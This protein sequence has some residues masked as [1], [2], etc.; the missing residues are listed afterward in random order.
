MTAQ[1]TQE[2]RMQESFSLAFKRTVLKPIVRGLMHVLPERGFE[3]FYATAFPAYKFA[4]RQSYFMSSLARFQFRDAGLWQRTRRVYSVA[5]YSLVGMGGLEATYDEAQRINAERVPSDFVEL[6]VARGGAAALLSL[7]AFDK[8]APEQRR[9]WLFDSYE[10]LPEPGA[11]DTA[12]D[13]TTGDHVRPLPKGSCLGTLDAVR[14]LLIDRF[15]LPADRINFVKGWFQD[16][17]PVTAPTMGKIAL[18]R[19]DGDW[20]ESTKIC[21]NHLYDHVSPGGAV[22]IDDYLSCVG[23]KKAVDEF[24]AERHLD[25][26]LIGDGRGGCYFRKP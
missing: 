10:G 7:G 3:K 9:V 15:R 20:Y 14:S 16:T 13:D 11:E 24:I 6:G 23:C 17:V 12:A 8:S 1:T 21:L 5:P 26:R 22:I 4:V 19:I 18:L 2:M 25:V